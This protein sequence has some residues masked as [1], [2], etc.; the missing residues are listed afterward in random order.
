M[1]ITKR[2]EFVTVAVY[3]AKPAEVIKTVIYEED[4]VE[5]HRKN[6]STEV[7]PTDDTTTLPA[8]AKL[9]VD[10]AYTP[11]RKADIQAFVDSRNPGPQ[12]P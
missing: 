10:A 5:F 7:L 12:N 4:G 9:A 6:T 1:A 8:A 11:A 2:E 3:D